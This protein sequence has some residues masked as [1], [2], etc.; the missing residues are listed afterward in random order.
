MKTN[1]KWSNDM[2]YIVYLIRTV[3]LEHPQI[4]V[5]SDVFDHFYSY[6]SVQ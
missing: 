3:D 6:F 5:F 2:Q 1:K 4:D